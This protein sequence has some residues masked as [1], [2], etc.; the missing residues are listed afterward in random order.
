MACS[1]VLVGEQ[2][3]LDYFAE[4]GYAAHA[5]SLR[6][7]GGSEGRERLRWTRLS[8]YIADVAQVARQLPSFLLIFPYG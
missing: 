6:G 7:Q 5:L 1:V 3:F 2:H 8:A 4:R